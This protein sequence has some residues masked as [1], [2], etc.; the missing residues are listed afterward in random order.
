[1]TG[2]SVGRGNQCILPTISK[3][4][5]TFP[6]KVLGSNPRPQRWEASVLPLKNT[7]KIKEKIIFKGLFVSF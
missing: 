4:L 5:P 7:E 6:H 3:Q 2:S 1:M